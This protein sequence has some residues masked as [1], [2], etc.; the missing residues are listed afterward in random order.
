MKYFAIIRLLNGVA[1]K[2]VKE[3]VLYKVY[4]LDTVAD[5]IKDQ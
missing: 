2:G 1:I 5:S 4:L 3:N